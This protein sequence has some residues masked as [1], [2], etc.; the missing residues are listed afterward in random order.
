MIK[1][2][3]MKLAEN[4]IVVPVEELENG[5][6]YVV[7]KSDLKAYKVGGYNI[8]VSDKDLNQAKRIEL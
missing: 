2:W 7:V 3:I 1:G 8:Y 5:W 4:F 6:V